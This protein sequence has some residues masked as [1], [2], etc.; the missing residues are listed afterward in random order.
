VLYVDGRRADVKQDVSN[1]FIRSDGK[2]RVKITDAVR[3]AHILTLSLFLS[4]SYDGSKFPTMFDL[5]LPL[6]ISSIFSFS[7]AHP[8]VFPLVSTSLLSS[9]L[10]FFP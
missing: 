8:V 4:L 2:P 1:A 9:H 6:S 7:K 5:V 3:A 10:T